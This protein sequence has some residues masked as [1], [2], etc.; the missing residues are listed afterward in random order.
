MSKHALHACCC[1]VRALACF[2][3]AARSTACMWMAKRRCFLLCSLRA[4]L[5]K[6]QLFCGGLLW[7]VGAYA[8]EKMGCKTSMAFAGMEGR[9]LR[10][11]TTIATSIQLGV[12]VAIV[13]IMV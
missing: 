6:L 5:R 9:Q 11:I 3:A 10:L 12:E 7:R 2:R 8:R 1:R 4:F 13:V